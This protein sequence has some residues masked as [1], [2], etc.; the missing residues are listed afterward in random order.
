MIFKKKKYAIQLWNGTSSK[1]F[2]MHSNSNSLQGRGLNI[3]SWKN[4]SEF[5]QF[6]K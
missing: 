6:V 4:N 1:T 5:Y 3:S 2:N